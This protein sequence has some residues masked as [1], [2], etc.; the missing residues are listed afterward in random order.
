V[1]TV[2]KKSRLEKGRRFSGRGASVNGRFFCP[3]RIVSALYPSVS[4]VQSVVTSPS[5][6]PL[7]PSGEITQR[8]RSRLSPLLRERRKRVLLQ[9]FPGGAV[10]CSK[11]AI[12]SIKLEA[13]V[14]QCLATNIGT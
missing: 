7:K 5:S 11:S 8:C 4:S 12:H 3:E 1:G 13:R 9:L 2:G 6:L 10:L 14:A